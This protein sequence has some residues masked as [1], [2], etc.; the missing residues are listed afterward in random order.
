MNNMITIDGYA[1]T[2]DV[3]KNKINILLPE[4]LA[5]ATDTV[6]QFVDRRTSVSNEEL[7]LILSL[8]KYI[9]SKDNF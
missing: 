5:T 1:I 8:V 6:G 2:Y 4:T 3:N 7:I 9:F